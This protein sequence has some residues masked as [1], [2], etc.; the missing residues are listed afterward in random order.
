[1][2]TPLRFPS[3]PPA[4][5]AAAA[6]ARALLLAALA[7]PLLAACSKPVEAPPPPGP[8]V[9][10]ERI[11]FA[12]GSAQINALSSA[13]VHPREFEA[14]N[15]SGRLIWNEDQTVRVMPA[16]AGRVTDILVKPGDAV[17]RGQT[18]ALM[19]SPDFGQVQTDLQSARA[20]FTLAKA[21]RDRLAELVEHGVAARKDLDAA[22][23]EFERTDAELRRAQARQT[24]YAKTGGIDQRLAI[25]APIAGIVVER[26]INPGQELRP[27]QALPN[28]RGGVFVITDPTTLWVML[29]AQERDL[30]A[31]QEGGRIMIRVQAL[32]AE[33][34]P[35]TIEHVADS[36]DP[37]SRTIKVRASV[38]NSDRKLKAEMFVVAQA[39]FKARNELEL[40]ASAVYLDGAQQYVFVEE[41]PGIYARRRVRAR[42]EID[43]HV[44]VYDGLNAGERVV[45]TGS[46]L[47]QRMLRPAGPAGRT[48][49]RDASS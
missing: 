5:I 21:N 26:N 38:D 17:R 11:E 32:S 10:A 28:N 36:L 34:F 3:A 41:G 42:P 40:P 1:M 31:L 2:T 7:G 20:S 19:A 47:L 22:R 39:Q 46:L 24:L 43:G 33:T 45:V 16:F 44:E 9:D 23:A 48:A 4:R 14:R 49:A 13:A 6:V 25:T 37:D 12:Q 27:D 30:V 29:D 8:K 35:A 15:L 18:L